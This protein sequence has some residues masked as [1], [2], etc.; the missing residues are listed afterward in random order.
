VNITAL[1][2]YGQPAQYKDIVYM[3]SSEEDIA[4]KFKVDIEY[5]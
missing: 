4:G 3:I 5:G 2:S 1:K